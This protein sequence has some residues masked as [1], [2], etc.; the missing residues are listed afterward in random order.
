MF[1]SHLPHLLLA[2]PSLSCAYLP[3]SGATL[4][5]HL[6][7]SYT[8]GA[9]PFVFLSHTR[10]DQQLTTRD[11]SHISS[12][13]L[14]RLGAQHLQRVAKVSK[15]LL[16]LFYRSHLVP[17]AGLFHRALLTFD[18]PHRIGAQR[19]QRVA[20]S[21]S[22]FIGLF[23]RSHL[24]RNVKGDAGGGALKQSAHEWKAIRRQQVSL[25]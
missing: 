17:F 19:L 21:A 14:H 9:Q 1:G 8:R 22:L 11:V 25:Q 13:A 5:R 3:G 20:T 16:G 23:Y 4:L 2:H 7:P 6:L 24:R 12:D 18:A 10:G 15:P